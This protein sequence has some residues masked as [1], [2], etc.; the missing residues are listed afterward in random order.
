[1][2]QCKNH[3]SV[4]QLPNATCLSA[5]AAD[6]SLA[7]CRESSR[8][9]RI[10]VR[11]VN[12]PANFLGRSA[13]GKSDVGSHHVHCIATMAA[14][15]SLERPWQSNRSRIGAT[16]SL[17]MRRPRY[18]SSFDTPSSS[19]SHCIALWIAR[20]ENPRCIKNRICFARPTES[21]AGPPNL[22][23]QT[24]CAR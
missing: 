11:A 23:S 20:W 18:S 16:A 24:S 22:R 9:F 12:S 5:N 6:D 10:N 8:I 3:E 13:Q 2:R 21:G 7:E 17:K 15:K 14:A 19:P 4:A 1:M